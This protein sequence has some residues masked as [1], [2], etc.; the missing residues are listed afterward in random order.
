MRTGWH[1]DGRSFVLPNVTI[2]DKCV[3]F[4]SEYVAHDDFIQQGDVKDWRECVGLKC[5]GNPILILSV[6]A[7]FAAPLLLRAKQQSAGGG[8]IHLVGKSSNGKT[9][10]LQ[11]AASVWGG[12]GYVRT[13]RATAN[14][15]EATAAA[16]NDS[17]LV[18]DEISE[19]DPREIRTIIYALANGH[20]KQRAQRTG[21]VR[22]SARWRTIVLSSGE[23]TLA[24]HMEES[25]QRI[26]AGQE[27][28]LLNIPA[29]RVSGNETNLMCRR[30]LIIMSYWLPV[31]Q[32]L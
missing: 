8:G 25:G 2:G 1:L 23:R 30:H 26:K 29:E 21:G 17:L 22:E 10:A 27:A 3:R 12:H 4:Q 15:L 32:S 11:V 7:A 31:V 24:A 19:C 6:S 18:L 16:L 9:T 28:R 20:G 5:R 14:G 13:W